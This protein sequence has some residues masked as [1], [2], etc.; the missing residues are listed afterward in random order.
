MK[1]LSCHCESVELEIKES[2]SALIKFLR[3]N[4]SMCIRKGTMVTTINKQD[5]KIIKG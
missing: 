1:K 2:E 4:C 5:L 3:C